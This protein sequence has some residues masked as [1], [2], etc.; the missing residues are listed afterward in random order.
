MPEPERIEDILG[1]D[2]Y[3]AT[4]Y[5]WLREYTPS[6]HRRWRFDLAVPELKIAVEV[7]GRRHG[8]AKAHVNDS[9]K[10]NYAVADGWRVLR[11]PASRVKSKARRALIV[12]QIYRVCCGVFDAAFDARVLS[13][14]AA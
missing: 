11:Y 6:E 13:G 4:G 8:T 14:E 1:R 10:F 7:E 2:L 9:E 12:E 5:K 3:K